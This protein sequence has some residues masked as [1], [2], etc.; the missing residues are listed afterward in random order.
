VNARILPGP[1][2]RSRVR[3]WD[4]A[5]R[6]LAHDIECAH[7]A[8]VNLGLALD[9]DLARDLAATLA[10]IY[11]LVWDDF[12]APGL[13]PRLARDLLL[14][15]ALDLA[16]SLV[17]DLDRGR[18]RDLGLALACE[19]EYSVRG[20]TRDATRIATLVAGVGWAAAQP[21]ALPTGH[22][23]A[24]NLSGVAQRIADFTARLLPAGYRADKAEEFACELYDLAEAGVPRRH[25]L[26]HALR[27][28]AQ[29]VPLRRE[30]SGSYHVV[31][32][33]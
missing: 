12:F 7:S 32:R 14:S 1:L 2:T 19:L 30:L 17:R 13:A 27:V 33:G 26:G 10:R 15:R 22:P 18:A 6:D 21:A 29:V 23:A 8:A 16:D 4:G 11:D 25:Q 31:D 24:A 9:H 20:L 28:L 3:D 5:A